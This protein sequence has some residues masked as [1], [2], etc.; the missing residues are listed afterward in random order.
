MKSKILLVSA[1]IPDELSHLPKIKI[2]EPLVN[3]YLEK[4]QKNIAFIENLTLPDTS[5]RKK[6][7]LIMANTR[8]KTAN[9]FNRI[10]EEVTA[11]NNKHKILYYISRG[12]RKKDRIKIID[13]LTPSIKQENYKANIIVVSTQVIEAGIDLSFSHIYRE[14]APLDSVIQIMGRLNREG[15]YKHDS[16]MA[17]FQEE[18]NHRPY[19]E[20]EYNESLPI[21][22]KVK[23]SKELYAQLPD[24][25]K[26]VSTKNAR[27]K[28][29]NDELNS[30]I[31]EMDFEK[32]WEFVNLHAL[33][34]DDKD[35]VFIP[36]TTEEWYQIKDA[37]LKAD[38]KSQQ[39]T[40]NSLSTIY[41]KFVT[42]TASLP[43]SISLFKIKDIFDEELFTEGILMPK[44]DYFQ[45]SE[46]LREIY[47]E[48]LGLDILL[49]NDQLY[50]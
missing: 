22:K 26:A 42:L 7:I 13:E 19:S 30:Y 37:F 36:Y 17:I 4:T 44:V 25:Y 21:L 40:K 31:S 50:Q 32:V 8:K 20:L 5:D 16:Y 9:I 49:R 45:N 12:I 1:T 39:F 10:K 34:D 28:K 41:K 24:Y 15:E 2:S 6:R 29:M 38:T 14:A 27:N 18:V 33:P 47:D 3:S 43:R 23:T 35:N 48:D 46:K 11:D